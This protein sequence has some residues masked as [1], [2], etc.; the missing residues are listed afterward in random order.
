MDVI[1]LHAAGFE[2]AVATLGTAITPEHARIMKRYTNKVIIAYDAD[3][4]GQRAAENAFRR[5]E[6]AGLE[7]KR[8][9]VEGAKDPDEYIQ[10]YGAAKFRTLL[11]VSRSRFDFRFSGILNRYDISQ[12]D[13]KIKAAQDFVNLISEFH[14]SAEQEVYLARCA[15]T[16]GI[17]PDSLRNDVRRQMR[18][19]EKEAQKE[20]TRQIIR[21]TEGY[22]DRVNPD[23][24]KNPR[25]SAAEETLLGILLRYPEKAS[26]LTEGETPLRTEEFFT[27][28][29][30][31]VYTAFLAHWKKGEPFDTGLLGE[32]LTPDEMSRVVRMAMNRTN[33]VNENDQILTDCVKILREEKEKETLSTVE[34]IQNRRQ[35]HS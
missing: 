25:A 1:A 19:R 7:T 24:I 8:L 11:E 22:G 30:A 15:E 35:K 31:R 3:D 32:N 12:P 29:G 27:E 5:L 28:F 6:E 14:S 2:N 33:L 34:L 20:Q 9:K 16:L 10:K 4:A 17:P 13:Q 21:Q 18:R 26:I 23:K